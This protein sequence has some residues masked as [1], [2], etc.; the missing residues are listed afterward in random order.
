MESIR[1]QAAAICQFRSR[2]SRSR[3]AIGKSLEFE[4]QQGRALRGKKCP[5][6]PPIERL[7]DFFRFSQGRLRDRASA[8][9][10]GCRQRRAR[11]RMGTQQVFTHMADGEDRQKRHDLG[12]GR[13]P[14]QFG[15]IEPADIIDRHMGFSGNALESEFML[16][17]L[18]GHGLH[19]GIR[20]QVGVP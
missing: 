6:G 17:V 20:G 3:R 7:G 2:Q 16:R 5:E 19:E 12:I 15:S 4:L 11:R 14:R 13:K 8:M 18:A 1:P 9:P 10:G